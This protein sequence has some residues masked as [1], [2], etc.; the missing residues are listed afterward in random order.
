MISFLFKIPVAAEWKVGYVFFL[1]LIAILHY[2][3]S[4]S[5]KALTFESYIIRLCHLLLLHSSIAL[6]YSLKNIPSGSLSFCPTEYIILKYITKQYIR[7][8]FF[9]FHYPLNSSSS[10]WILIYLLYFLNLSSGILFSIL[11]ESL[12]PVVILLTLCTS[13]NPI[14]S[15]SDILLFE[16]HWSFQLTSSSTPTLTVHQPS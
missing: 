4:S 15:I 9:W 7:Q 2:F 6:R 5:L 16:C 13:V 1:L 8:I 3:H 11:F 10:T 14:I 12:S